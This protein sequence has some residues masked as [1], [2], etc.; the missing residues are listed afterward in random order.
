MLDKSQKYVDGI[1][2]GDISSLSRAITLIESNNPNHQV[3]A[4]EILS[5]CLNH[6]GNSVRIG[7]SGMPGVGKSTIIDVIGKKLIEAG[8]KVA[9]LAVD[10][11]SS[12]SKGSILGDKTRMEYLSSNENAFIR[13]SPSSGT[14][15][16]VARKTKDLIT[17][18]E[19]AGYDRIIVETVGI[20]QSEIEVRSITDLF[21]L[22]IL[23]AGGD[24]LQ[25][26]KKGAVELADMIVINKADGDKA[27]IA[28]ITRSD[29]QNALRIVRSHDKIKVPV[30]ETSAYEE[31]GIDELIDQINNLIEQKRN[32]G[33]FLSN[34]KQQ[35]KDWFEKVFK[36]AI[37]N[38]FFS[39]KEKQDKIEAIENK[40]LKGEITILKAIEQLF[41]QL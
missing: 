4:Q 29:Y 40:I 6:S 27:K 15:G 3:L 19:A 39:D 7:I 14:L 9:V 16:G 31:T 38:K 11:S 18:F 10:P 21:I 28:R 34:R 2:N 30:L 24:D 41:K 22:L 36:E 13:P 32:S 12:L 23:P 33:E 35:D 25:G 5:E 37:I 1:L 8:H 17:L 20:G 26:I